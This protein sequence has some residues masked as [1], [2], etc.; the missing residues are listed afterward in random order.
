MVKYTVTKVSEDCATKFLE[1][2]GVNLVCPYHTSFDENGKPSNVECGDWCPMLDLQDLKDGKQVAYL[3]C[4]SG[5][6]AYSIEK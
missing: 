3:L 6:A 4:G 1:R 2:D 5:E